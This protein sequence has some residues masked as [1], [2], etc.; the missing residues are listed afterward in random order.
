MNSFCQEQKYFIFFNFK[1]MNFLMKV[2]GMSKYVPGTV[3]SDRLRKRTV[4][5]VIIA[6]KDLQAFM[7][8]NSSLMIKYF[9]M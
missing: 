6:F 7:F 3:S 4:N 9:K 2:A 5:K 8:L 1:A